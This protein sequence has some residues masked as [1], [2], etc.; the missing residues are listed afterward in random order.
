[1][2]T[3]QIYP[4]RFTTPGVQA[5]LLENP[6]IS[7]PNGIQITLATEFF[8]LSV[9]SKGNTIASPI[10]VPIL[11]VK[12]GRYFIFNTNNADGT[13]REITSNDAQTAL[14]AIVK[15]FKPGVIKVLAFDPRDP[16]S[17]NFFEPITQNT[18]GSQTRIID[19]K[20]LEELYG[21]T[22][23]KGLPVF[24]GTVGGSTSAE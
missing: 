13:V 21:F 8:I 10:V 7:F 1:M 2:S 15:K 11:G 14:Q 19:L 9:D 17:D 23:V 12:D 16:M 5:R 4:D 6:D 22:N 24:S 18:T 3:T 20:P